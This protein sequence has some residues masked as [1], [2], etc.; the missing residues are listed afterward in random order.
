MIKDYRYIL[1]TVVISAGLMGCVSKSEHNSVVAERDQLRQKVAAL[2]K[3]IAML[4]KNNA[5]FEQAVASL[6]QEKQAADRK[7]SELSTKFDALNQEHEKLKA[8]VAA[9]KQT[10]QQAD[11]LPVV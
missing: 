5:S 2:Q 9:V 8:D 11:L 1:L 6:G 3:D 4:E 10:G 7:A